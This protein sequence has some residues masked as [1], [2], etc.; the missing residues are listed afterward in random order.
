MMLFRYF[1]ST[2][3]ASG[4]DSYV[5]SRFE[6]VLP[7]GRA[8]DAPTDIGW[9][10]DCR[11]L[12]PIETLARDHWAGMIRLV[13][14]RLTSIALKRRLLR[15]SLMTYEED[16]GDDKPYA[17]PLEPDV[18]TGWQEQLDRALAGFDFLALRKSPPHCIECGGTNFERSGFM[19]PGCG[20]KFEPQERAHVFFGAGGYPRPFQ[21]NVEGELL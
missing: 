3:H 5:G 17:M 11:G 1:C 7:D 21:M 15:S 14:K 10:H 4:N 2:C 8:T 18:L 12:R 13:G 9:C 20:G 6:Y 16:W 19:H